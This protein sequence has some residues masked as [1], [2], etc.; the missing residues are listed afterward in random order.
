MATTTAQQTTRQTWNVAKLPL[1]MRMMPER[2][3]TDDEIQEFSA[4]N[5][6]IRVER[7]SDGT[8]MMMTP[9]GGRGN[10]RESYVAR[11]LSYWSDGDGR[12]VA[13]GDNAGFSLPDGSLLSPDSAWLANED[14]FA[15]SA[16]QQEKYLPLCPQFVVEVLSASDSP[17]E[18]EA[19]MQQWIAN[20]AE[21]GWMIDPYAGVVSVFRPG[22]AME[23]IARPEEMRGEG[24]VAGFVLKMARLWA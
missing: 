18:L 12:G 13:F 11:E 15:L 10:L 7:R 1:P 21:L 22:H 16:A 8:I 4:A 23:R 3:W 14:W 2:S 6:T 17:S 19:K 9:A 20:G 5:H 24:P